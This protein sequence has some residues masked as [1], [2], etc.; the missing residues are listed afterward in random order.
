[1]PIINNYTKGSTKKLKEE[2]FLSVRKKYFN[3]ISRFN[4]KENVVTDKM[5]LNYQNIGF[6]LSSFPSDQGLTSVL[7]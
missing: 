7:A 3:S 4:I 6:I 2:D 5:P 1:M